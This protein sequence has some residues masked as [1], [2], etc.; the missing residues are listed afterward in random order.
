[1]LES[2][3]LETTEELTEMNTAIILGNNIAN[4]QSFL[5]AYEQI[6]HNKLHRT[7]IGKL[8]NLVRC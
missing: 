4:P 5:Q 8:S 7:N 1:M 6:L 3:L 2:L